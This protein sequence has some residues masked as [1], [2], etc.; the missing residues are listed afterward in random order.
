MTVVDLS[1]Q[2]VSGV[3]AA[4][5]Q[6]LKAGAYPTGRVWRTGFD[7]L[8]KH[9]TGGMRSGELVLLGGPQG[10]GKT[11]WV[12][13]VARNIARSGRQ[14]VVFSFEHDLESLLV[15]LV[16]LE[17]GHLAGIAAPNINRIRATFEAMDGRT[18]SL[19]E[20]LANTES[21]VQAVEVVQEYADRMHL[22][23]STGSSTGLSAVATAI[24][25]VVDSTGEQ[26]LVV[27]D[28]LQKLHVS[29]RYGD[30][31]DRVTQIVEGLKDLAL[32]RDVPVLAVVASDM[33][34]LAAGKRMRVHN[35]RGSSALAYE[36][37][38][39]LMLNHKYDVVARHHLVYNTGNMER[40][41]NWAVL[42]VEKNRNGRDGGAMEFMKRFEQ[43]R[44]ETTGRLVTEQ[45]VDERVFV[46]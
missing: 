20:R 31:A 38:T 2:S 45:L 5:D 36:A 11:T 43:A 23:R 26:P 32:E 39:V 40:F 42:S 27:V 3:I 4:A 41:K 13:Q 10:L 9:L 18:G 19:T 44:F 12:M 35:L 15:R 1:L 16:A 46:E 14:V 17:A 30:D 29:Q 34:G 22:V 25:E 33:D 6:R 7:P 24:D 28:Y 8:D 37:D 21:G